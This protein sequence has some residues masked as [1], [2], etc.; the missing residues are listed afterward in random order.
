MPHIELRQDAESVST[1]GG[2]ARYH[3][4]FDDQPIVVT[5]AIDDLL[6]AF[7]EL[8]G[9]GED[10]IIRMRLT[11]ET[12]ANRVVEEGRLPDRSDDGI[13]EGASIFGLALTIDDLMPP[14]QKPHAL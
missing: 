12:D 2:I 5:A 8:R 13:A 1:I 9:E 10:W 7:P 11:V 4:T 6:Q 14:K 3:G